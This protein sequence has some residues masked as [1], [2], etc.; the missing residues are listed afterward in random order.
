MN[1]QEIK[2]NLCE[3]KFELVTTK[4]GLSKTARFFLSASIARPELLGMFCSVAKS[5]QV[6][7]SQKIYFMENEVKIETSFQDV[8]RK[9]L[10]M[11]N[12]IYPI[13]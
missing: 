2:C 1:N 8:G 5:E 4:G 6:Y 3:H 10:L 11:I 13:R 12:P 9:A 7:K